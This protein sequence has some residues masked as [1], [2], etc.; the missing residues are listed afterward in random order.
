MSEEEEIPIFSTRAMYKFGG[1]DEHFVSYDFSILGAHLF[2]PFFNTLPNMIYKKTER[3]SFS[4]QM[5]AE[6]KN[7]G[8]VDMKRMETIKESI[9]IK[10]PSFLAYLIKI[11][12]QTLPKSKKLISLE[13]VSMDI[14]SNLMVN[15]FD[16]IGNCRSLQKLYFKNI[17]I[18]DEDFQHLLTLI[19]PYQY[20]SIS[21]VNCSLT[22]ASFDAI[23]QFID[24][25]PKMTSQYVR[26]LKEFNVDDNNFALEELNKIEE[27]VNEARKDAENMPKPAP[28]EQQVSY[29]IND[30]KIRRLQERNLNIE[31]EDSP[32]KLEKE[33]S[34]SDDGAYCSSHRQNMSYAS[35]ARSYKSLSKKPKPKPVMPIKIER[36]PTTDE[37]ASK[38]IFDLPNYS[39]P[40]HVYR[41]FQHQQEEDA[42]G[43]IL[44]NFDLNSLPDPHDMSV[45]DIKKQNE[46]LQDVLDSYLRKYKVVKYADDIFLVGEG[47]Q[48]MNEVVSVMK[49]QMKEYEQVTKEEQEFRDRRAL[50]SKK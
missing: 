44:L 8:K 9:L 36:V 48:D 43:D 4:C 24:S 46:Y 31:G 10:K 23:K 29:E 7:A 14:P 12:T 21:F 13:F 33:S 11:L 32:I 47:A 34:S 6:Y 16:A 2:Q 30:H 1:G 25:T 40:P 38:D 5:D 39:Y 15:L 17:K 18:K 50:L 45:E 42:K 20:K 49:E 41:H 27:L 22:S 19:S 28:D 26:I 35:Q 3:I 37:F